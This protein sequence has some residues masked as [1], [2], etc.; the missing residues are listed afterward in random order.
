MLFTDVAD[1]TM[2]IAATQ[3]KHRLIRRHK[4]FSTCH[5]SNVYKAAMNVDVVFQFI[6]HLTCELCT[7]FHSFV[8]SVFLIIL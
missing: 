6:Q 3:V 7:F 4:V 2:T 1:S 5:S 8:C